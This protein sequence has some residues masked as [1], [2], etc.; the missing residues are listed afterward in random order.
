MKIE[1]WSWVKF[2]WWY[3]VFQNWVIVNMK[4]KILKQSTDRY[5]YKYLWLYHYWIRKKY[6]VHRLVAMCFIENPENKPQVNHIDWN[7]ENNHISN[8]EWSTAKENTNHADNNWLRNISWTN[9]YLSKW[10]IKYDINMNLIQE[11]WTMTEA[12]LLNWLHRWNI[13]KVCSWKRN[14]SWWFIWKYK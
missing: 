7:K 12:A 8:L 1:L 3:T 6:T 9:N 11:Y 13:S 2:H 4:W 10:V 14:T 5:W